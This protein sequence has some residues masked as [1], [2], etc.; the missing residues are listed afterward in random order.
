[1]N[2]RGEV[3]GFADHVAAG[4]DGAAAK[5]AQDDQAAGV[6]GRFV[7]ELL[8]NRV[9]VASLGFEIEDD[10]VGPVRADQ[11][12]PFIGCVRLQNLQAAACQ[13]GAQDFAIFGRAI[14]DQNA[15]RIHGAGEYRRAGSLSK[16]K[17]ALGWRPQ[18]GQNGRPM[19]L[20]H[21]RHI[22]EYLAVRVA[23]SLIQAVSIETCAALTSWLAWLAAD[24]FRIRDRVVSENL[25]IAF[26]EK[27]D[28]ERRA[29]TRRMWEH[30]LLMVCEVAHLQRK[31]HET[32]WRKYVVIPNK[33]RWILVVSQPGPKVCV[34]GHFGNF[35]T[36]GHV[37]NFWGFRT[38]TV[39]RTLDNPYLDRLV[40]RFRESMGQRIL[41]KSDSAGQADEV[42][43]TGGILALLGD[44]HAGR[45]GCIVD[46]L[47]RPASC[48]K[49]LALFALLNRAPLLVATC[50][51]TDRPLRF[52]MQMDA[53]V[54]P[55]TNP[56][57][58]SSVEALT[59]WYNDWLARRIRQQPEQYWW[60]HDRWKEV[61]AKRRKPKRPASAAGEV[62][63][64]AA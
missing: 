59:Q 9:G 2:Q 10:H 54:D 1:M 29:L 56:H 19:S 33:R 7:G 27:S 41:P 61:A 18:G 6:A 48:H 25:R 46:F 24:I 34:T 31:I 37:S 55:A 22:A 26:P 42:L 15:G 63:R 30:L 5:L 28:G 38:F 58:F 23:L 20:R 4:E 45:K 21:L 8:A 36:L 14:D 35:E 62:Q 32:N 53:I 49:A 3:V 39:A 51:R 16:P 11:F 17:I 13:H 12:E 47:G 52:C 64:P 43:Q 44:Q 40:A 60:L 57:E 50:T